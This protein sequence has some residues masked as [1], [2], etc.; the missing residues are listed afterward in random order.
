MDE[1][2]GRPK[3][4]P[5]A[6]GGGGVVVLGGGEASGPLYPPAVIDESLFS[7]ESAA[8]AAFSEAQLLPQDIVSARGLQPATTFH[9][10]SP[11]PRCQLRSTAAS[12]RIGTGSTIASRFASCAPLR[13][14]ASP[15]PVEAAH[16][17]RQCMSKRSASSTRP[18]GKPARR[19]EPAL[20]PCVSERRPIFDHPRV[21]A[22]R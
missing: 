18:P 4:S 8:R 17:S 12:H 7:C 3:L 2:L 14:A 19:P 1:R 6:A 10:P 16:G 21:T 11:L 9:C 15:R 13:L 5:K 22:S 20:Y